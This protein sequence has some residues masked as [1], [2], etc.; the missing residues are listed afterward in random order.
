[1]RKRQIDQSNNENATTTDILLFDKEQPHM[2][3]KIFS[4]IEYNRVIRKVLPSLGRTLDKLLYKLD[5]RR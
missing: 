4:N 5:D 1:M 3:S 2:Q